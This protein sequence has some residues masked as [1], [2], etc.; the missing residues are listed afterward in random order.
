LR[1]FYLQVAK[2]DFFCD[3]AR[4]QHETTRQIRAQRGAIF[5]SQGRE[6]AVSIKSPSIYAE[7]HLIRNHEELAGILAPVL[8]MK[9]ADLV[10]LLKRDSKFSWLKRM[11]VE[12]TAGEVSVLNIPGIGVRYEDQRLYP[13]EGLTSHVLGF[14]GHDNHGLEGLELE[15]NSY[16]AGADGWVLMEKDGY[17]RRIFLWQNKV[18]H[19]LNG[20]SLQLSI[21]SVIQSIVE[22]KLIEGIKKYNAL[23]GTVIVLEPD[24]GKI[25]ALANYPDF[26]PNNFEKEDPDAL[27]NRGLTDYYEPGSAFKIVAASAALNEKKAKIDDIF[28]C[29]AG[30]Y[31]YRGHTLHDHKP[32]DNLTFSEVIEFSSNIGAC[33]IAQLLGNELF[34]EYIRKF[35]FGE[36]TGIDL[37]GEVVGHIRSPRQW[38]KIS[39]TALPMGQ[40]IGVTALQMAMAVSVIANGGLLVKPYLVNE[41]R[42]EKNEIIISFKPQVKHRVI[43]EETAETMR[44]ILSRVVENGTGKKA[45]LKEVK[46]AGKTGTSQKLED[47]GSYSHRKFI[48]S[49]IGFFPADDPKIAMVVVY[50]EPKPVYYGGS[51]AAPVFRKIASEII[52]YLKL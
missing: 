44:G 42:D 35:G 14:A 16:L 27:R 31:R 10:L 26:N 30:T 8:L 52:R 41:I 12:E 39:I 46:V 1:F 43:T 24:T 5:D 29:E 15:Y 19:A 40:E 49:F 25:L 11:V 47:D 37:P 18:N 4:Q 2:N 34:Y 9:E 20:Y 23:S 28:D 6:L 32:H 7:P 50:D 3:L 22:E 48:A 45:Y 13:N 36:L 21:E 51:V 33:K 38:S 17:R